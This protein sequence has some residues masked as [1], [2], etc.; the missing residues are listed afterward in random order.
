MSQKTINFLNGLISADKI[1]CCSMKLMM[2]TLVLQN[3]F[4]IPKTQLKLQF[5]KRFKILIDS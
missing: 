1:T 3:L 2:V 5:D 4:A